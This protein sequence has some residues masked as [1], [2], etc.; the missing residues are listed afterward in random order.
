[1][2]QVGKISDKLYGLVGLRQPFNPTYAILDASNQIS[3]SGYYV[4]DNPYIKLEYIK[5]SQDYK[6]I[7][8]ADF[9]LYLK[10]LQQ[11][12][13]ASLCHK[14]FNRFDYLDRNLLYKNAQ[15][16]V[17]QSV[18]TDGF[19]GYKIEVDSRNDIAFEIKRVLL[20]FDTTGTFKLML[21]N[22]SKSAPIESQDIT[23]TTTTQEFVLDWKVDN[24]DI[25]YKGDYYLGY[26][27]TG[28]TPIPYKRDYQSANLMTRFSEIEVEK[29]QVNGHSTETLF[30]LTDVE[31][32]SEDIGINPD[33][34]IYEDFTDLIINNEALFARA[35]KI[36]FSIAILREQINSLRTNANKADAE[37]Q[38]MR[39]LAEIEGTGGD[40]VLKITGLRPTLLGEIKL[41]SKEIDRL[42]VGYFNNA[43]RVS[44]IF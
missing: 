5:D 39:I 18:L 34:T 10:R 26:I 15:N 21:F 29:I 24:S 12:S 43:M 40:N 23:I 3:R 22:T 14:V 19:V 32:L 11:S 38:T 35:I 27:K 36:E 7:S 4:T 6:N 9:N 8:D 31:G 1:M 28:T 41:I 25:T 30:D 2:F 17:N 13:I 20:D 33:I 16:K 42:K 37:K 44:T